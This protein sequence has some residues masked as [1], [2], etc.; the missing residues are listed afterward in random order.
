MIALK[1]RSEAGHQVGVGP[2]FDMGPYYVTAL[3]ALLGPVLRATGSA[4]FPIPEKARPDAPGETF[5]VQTP[6]TIGAVLDFEDGV[7]GSLAA[8]CDCSGY[9]PRFEVY[10]TEATLVAPD[11]N[12][13]GGPVALR[14]PHGKV[15]EVPLD[16]GAC[17]RDRG[18]GVAEMALAIRSGRLHR[19]S[20]QLAYHVL[21]VMHAVHEA[22]EEGKHVEIRSRVSRPEPLPGGLALSA[23]E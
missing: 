20:G 16:Q 15:E 21:D 11:P 13:F 6:S 1:Y 10:G 17:G 18:L 22:S 2:M 8:S 12:R 3:V 4:Q 9:F 7:V 19:A 5:K 23:L 14:H